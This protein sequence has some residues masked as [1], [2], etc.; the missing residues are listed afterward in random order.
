MKNNSN[1]DNSYSLENIDN[2]H[3]SIDIYEIDLLNK[4]IDLISEYFIFITG[5]MKIKNKNYINFIIRRG[6]ETI[7]NIFMLTEV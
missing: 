7:T 6:F 2:Y 1:L 4:Y 3:K 5:N